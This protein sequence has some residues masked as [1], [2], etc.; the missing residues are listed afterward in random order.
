MGLFRKKLEFRTI[1]FVEQQKAFDYPKHLPL[2]RIGELVQIDGIFGRVVDV[3]HSISGTV[4]EIRV[5]CQR[6]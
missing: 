4:T 2:P 5:K 6:T 1:D 3:R